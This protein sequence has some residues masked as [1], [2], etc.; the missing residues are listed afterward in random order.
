L[1]GIFPHPGL[2]L[3]ID[4]LNRAGNVDRAGFVAGQFHLFF[5]LQPETAAGQAD[6]AR[7]IDIAIILP[8]QLGQKRIGLAGAVEEGRGNAAMEF[9]VDQHAHIAVGVENAGQRPGGTRLGR[10]EVAHIGAARAEDFLRDIGIVRWAEQRGDVE[11]EGRG[12]DRQQFEI[13][14][15]GREEDMRAVALAADA[16]KD[17]AALHF[18]QARRIAVRIIIED[19]IEKDIFRGEAGHA[20]PHV[21]GDQLQFFF[22]FFRI[23]HAQVGHGDAMTPHQRAYAACRSIDEIRCRL[24]RQQ[25]QEEQHTENRMRRQPVVE[26]LQLLAPAEQGKFEFQIHARLS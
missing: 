14:G 10:H 1:A 8:C 2:D 9:L 15:M 24:R 7:G 26:C 21:A 16:F 4:Q 11:I 12:A 17:F 25:P 3:V 13:A 19:C 20:A 6:A 18:D 5:Q 23:G 22:G